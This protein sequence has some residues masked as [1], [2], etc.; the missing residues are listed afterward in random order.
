M[1]M[2]VFEFSFLGLLMP[3]I[4]FIEACTRGPKMWCTDSQQKQT[5]IRLDN[6]HNG[7]GFHL[8]N[9]ISYTLV[10]RS[11]VMS[12]LKMFLTSIFSVIYGE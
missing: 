4:N 11:V 2:C 9:V 12:A 10:A 5:Y 1:S 3:E 6:V 7:L 8:C